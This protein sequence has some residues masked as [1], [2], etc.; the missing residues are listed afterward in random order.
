MKENKLLNF[1]GCKLSKDNK[2]LV[3]TLISGK[4]DNKQYFNALVDLDVKSKRKV[5]AKIDLNKG[6]GIVAI[7]VLKMNEKKQQD[8]C[9]ENLPF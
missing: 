3:I 6:L 8:I 1:Y 4:N 7:P 2:Y 9:D 5:K